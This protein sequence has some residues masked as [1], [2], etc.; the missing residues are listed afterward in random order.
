MNLKSKEEIRKQTQ[1]LVEL[2]QRNG[3]QVKK[4]QEL[5]KEQQIVRKTLQRALQQTPRSIPQLAVTTNIAAH[6]ILW[7]IA[8]M[9][10]YGAVEEAGMDETGEYYLYGL[11]KE[12]K[13]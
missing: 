4:A 1:M 10:K 6:L 2:R 8:A 9:K 13:S 7:H 5:L 12:V 11:V 3:A